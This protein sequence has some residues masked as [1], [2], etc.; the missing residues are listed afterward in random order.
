MRVRIQK[1][2]GKRLSSR[3]GHRSRAFINMHAQSE[4]AGDALV[5]RELIQLVSSRVPADVYLG[6]W[7]E[8]FVRQLNISENSAVFPHQDRRPAGLVWDVMRARVAGWRCYYFLTAGAPHGERTLKQFGSDLL[9]IGWLAV[10][11]ALRV[12]IC[13]VGVSFENIGPRHAR[14]LRWRSRL[15]YASVPRD[16]ISQ[17]YMR[18][19]GIRVT[20]VMPDVTL[21]LFRTPTT[22]YGSKRDAVA[23]SFRNDKYPEIRGRAREL[24]I[25]ICASAPADTQFLFVAQVAR[26]VGFMLELAE[27][28]EEAHPGRVKFIDAHQDIDK[29]FATYRTCSA[30]FSNRLHA[31]LPSLKEGA[32][33]FAML[34]PGRDPKIEGVFESIDLS[35][36]VFDVKS[37]DFRELSERMVPIKFEGR[38]AAQ[39]LNSFFDSLLDV[40]E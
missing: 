38:V 12:R 22:P 21:N 20:G 27:L 11:A 34:V 26:D 9:R 35:D 19:L 8:G 6:K 39:E 1:A 25:Q 7:P 4:N 14:I 2:A 37:T 32:T 28:A 5:L 17:S 3:P 36:L 40:A 33:P 29:A 24:V 30:V 18:S 16:N 15:L 31:L 13:Q 23:F 10:L